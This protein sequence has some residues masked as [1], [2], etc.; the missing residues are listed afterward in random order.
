M[1]NTCG[2]GERE[3]LG[4]LVSRESLGSL[5]LEVLS[6]RVLSR[7]YSS[8]PYSS[9]SIFTDEC[10]FALFTNISSTYE[11]I[12]SRLKLLEFNASIACIHVNK[13]GLKNMIILLL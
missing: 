6:R 12:D 13:H 7:P 9:V 1:T 4:S 5:V 2:N 11:L 8:G 10:V 3:S